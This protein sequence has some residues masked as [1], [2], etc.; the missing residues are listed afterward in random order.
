MKHPFKNSNITFSISRNVWRYVLKNILINIKLIIIFL[1]IYFLISMIPI[2]ISSMNSSQSL[3]AFGDSTLFVKDDN[4]KINI[5]SISSIFN[6]ITF[7]PTTIIVTI[8]FV[9]LFSNKTIS[10]ELERGSISF[11]LVKPIKVKDIIWIKTITIYLTIISCWLISFLISSISLV[12]IVDKNQIA[13]AFLKMFQ[14]L[15][16]LLFLTSIVIYTNL[17]LVESREWFNILWFSI[18]I[19]TIFSMVAPMFISNPI[20]KFLGIESILPRITD[21]SNHEINNVIEF[22]SGNTDFFQVFYKK[23]EIGVYGIIQYVLFL[24][25]ILFSIITINFIGI[26][27]KWSNKEFNI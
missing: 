7:G 12:G 6:T 11:W 24:P 16:I 1:V 8:V 5:I 27:I 3:K 18:I 22:T 26:N 13:F 15:I 20:V 2:V 19:Y 4:F 9:L 14:H 17:L 23:N 10:G 21:Y 25:L